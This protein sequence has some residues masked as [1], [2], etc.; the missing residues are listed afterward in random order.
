MLENWRYNRAL[1]AC[2]K[3]PGPEPKSVLLSEEYK[4]QHVLENL[5]VKENVSPSEVDRVGRILMCPELL[6]NLRIPYAVEVLGMPHS[7]KTTMISRYLE[8]LGQ[9]DERNNVALVDEGARSIEDEYGNL[10]FSDPFTYSL[11]GGTQTFINYIESI[12]KAS[13][14]TRMIISDRGQIDRRVFRRALFQSG[15]VNPEIMVEEEEFIYGMENTPVQLGGIIMFIQR[16]YVSLERGATDNKDH[17][18]SNM[19]FLPRL[20][21]QYWR[22]HWEA[23][24]A[25]IPYRIYTCIDSEKGMDEVYGRFKYAVDSILN[26]HGT[27]LTAFA[28]AF[29]HEFDKIKKLVDEGKL[30]ESAAQKILSEKLGGR[31][32]IVGGDDMESEDDIFKRPFFE[33]MDLR[34][35]KG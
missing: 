7:G 19:N 32:K 15:E 16:P 21:E 20:Y 30:Q 23:T 14:G 12:R 27:L 4:T 28:K 18:V 17:P 6:L 22:L 11:L 29:P 13:L 24:Q 25:K 31:V 33:V 34:K 5:G 1:E 9:S 3:R 26:I 8:E 2:K 10:R 35:E